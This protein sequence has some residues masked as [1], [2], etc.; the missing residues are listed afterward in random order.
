MESFNIN[1]E[2]MTKEEYNHD[3]FMILQSAIEIDDESIIRQATNELVEFN[4][5]MLHKI[6]HDITNFNCEYED[7]FNNAVIAFIQIVREKAKDPDAKFGGAIFTSVKNEVKEMTYEQTADV[8]KSYSTKKRH[9]REAT[10]AAIDDSGFI[11]P[12]KFDEA[13]AERNLKRGSLDSYDI[14]ESV[15]SAE[16]VYCEKEKQSIIHDALLY[17][18]NKADLKEIDRQII[19]LRIEENLTWVEIAEALGNYS[20]AGVKKRFNRIMTKLRDIMDEYD[21]YAITYVA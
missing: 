21:K 4:S 3:L 5:K 10:A 7:L 17:V 12:D 9:V 15:A 20:N 13:Y 18:M 11:N 8:T 14:T 1:K 2:A 16:D 6:C 19:T